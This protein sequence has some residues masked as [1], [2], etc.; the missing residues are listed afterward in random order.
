MA[1]IYSKVST[2]ITDQ[3]PE[4]VRADHPDFLAFLKAYYEFLESAELKLKDFGSSDSIKYEL[5]NSTYIILEDTNRY[6]TGESNN[7][8][9]ED[10]DTVGGTKARS[11]G[12]FLNGETIT[13]QTSKA[14]AVIRV[15]DINNGSRL[16]ISSQNKFKLG[17]QIVGQTS[18]T[19]AYIVSYTANPVQNIMQLLEYADVDD[20]IEAFFIEFKNSFMRSLPDKLA[21]G[22]NKKSILKNIKDLYRSKGTK[23][24]HKLFFRILL[25]E[26]A[27]LYYPTK[28]L[29]RVSDGKWTEDTTL[30]VVPT[31]STLQDEE[32]SDT[33]G[34]IFILH[35]DG[36]QILLEDS[37]NGIDD[38]NLLV[39]QTITQQAVF[40]RTILQGGAFY[41]K[42]Y[43]TIKRTTAVVDNVRQ[44]S[45]GGELI[46]E[47]V[48]NPGSIDGEFIIGQ[49]ITG[50]NNT[51]IELDVSAKIAASINKP[52]FPTG[53]YSINTNV[54][55]PDRVTITADVGLGG[56]SYVTAYSAGTIKNIIVDS[57]GSG[58]VIGDTITVDNTNTNGAALQAEVSIVNGGFIPEDG[59]VTGEFR[60]TLED[61]TT[62]A[63]GEMLL[64]ESVIT[65]DRPTGVFEVGETFN[66]LTSGATGIVIEFIEDAKKILYSPVTGSFSSG[67]L[68]YGN[69]SEYTVRL[70]TNTVDTF[71][72]NEEDTGMLSTDRFV[73]ETETITGD[74]YDGS[75]MV[76]ETNT[77][78]GDVTDVRVTTTGY[79]YTSLPSLTVENSSPLGTGA[80]VRAKG[81][82]VGLVRAIDVLD[83]GIH[84]TDQDSL[85]F[86]VPTKFLCIQKTGLFTQYE[87]LTGSTSGAT[88]R[89]ISQESSTGI[90]KMDQLSAA[91]FLH[92]ETIT[93]SISLET[94][95]ID[96][97][98]EEV[99]TGTVDAAIKRTGKFVGEDGFV[100]E[101]AKRIQDSLYWQDYSY[102]VITET[103]IVEWRDDL[104]STVH[105]AGWKVF[106]R[107][108]IVSRLSQLANITS[109]DGLGTFYRVI[110]PALLG[111]R[112]GTT[113][114][115]P[116]NPT[117]TTEA[118][119]PGD[120]DRLYENTLQAATGSLFTLTEVITGGTSGA[121]AKVV[122]DITNDE[123]IRLLRY[124]PLT[125]IFQASET[126]T[127][128]TSSVSSTVIEVFGLRGQRDRTLYKY[129][130]VDFYTGGSELT[131]SAPT[132]DDLKDFKFAQSMVDSNA[133]SLT[134]R[135]HDVYAVLIP[136]TSLNGGINNSVTT[137][138][139]TDATNYPTAGTIKIGNE[140]IDYTGKSGNDLTGC[141]RGSHSTSPDSHSSGDVVNF[142][143]WGIKQNKVSGYRLM[144]WATDYQGNVLTLD[145][146]VNYP[147]NKNNI[148]P[149]S[150]ITLYKT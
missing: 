33:N 25:D 147:K 36:S 38:L 123:G 109:V 96:S 66:G 14:T 137:I 21:T 111:M 67:E 13:G 98:V 90:V 64:E 77:G 71:I 75:V 17:E 76:Q 91:P 128:G 45:L 72:A 82:D 48:L 97:Y 44:F 142:V 70:T 92:G 101:G 57:G 49:D 8:L 42:G 11:N 102:E 55:I 110:F 39:G 5:G 149:P 138:T 87:T 103:S 132:Y 115:G 46:T 54:G 2:H 26:E 51:N 99:I 63:P 83:C 47:L 145:D 1:T 135:G 114:Q 118:N 95:V 146:F 88:G 19:T 7:I 139:L 134:F 86:V 100:S 68:L 136:F 148:S 60:I 106:G 133:S 22:L 78:V 61:G 127:G 41:N 93:G 81:T 140:L 85:R 116:L 126:I 74:V 34:D 23:K 40:D 24:G 89:F 131:S 108:D 31:N 69:S 4:F 65:F 18:G 112:L 130:T 53:D 29:L 120:S 94:A 107:L 58:Y 122:E 121:T 144:D 150:E 62:G 32:A 20:T 35:E 9:L 79:G 56:V 43:K 129:R 113:S 6:R 80:V 141:S 15:E 10:Y 52:V 28:D 117:P 50:P 16:F 12:A 105:P 119:E 125:G 59:S 84:Y 143:K 124:V 104:L 27:E 73:Y 37:V 3:Q 30:R